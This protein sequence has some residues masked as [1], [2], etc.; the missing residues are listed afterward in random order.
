MRQWRTV[1]H[2]PEYL[3]DR[4]TFCR[5]PGSSPTADSHRSQEPSRRSLAALQGLSLSL[6]NVEAHA[7][8]QEQETRGLRELT[9]FLRELQTS[10]PIRSPAQQFEMLQ[11][12]R[13]WLLWLPVSL[14]DYGVKHAG[15]LIVLA[16]VYAAALIMERLFPDVGA[17]CFGNMSIGPMEEFTRTLNDMQATNIISPT[18][19]NPLALIEMPLE[20][21]AMTRPTIGL[22]QESDGLYS[23]IVIDHHHQHAP[24]P[25]MGR[26]TL[27]TEASD[28][29]ERTSARSVSYSS[30]G[31]RSAASPMVNDFTSP[32]AMAPAPHAYY[33]SPLGQVDH[34]HA[35]QQAH[36]NVHAAPPNHHA[37][38]SGM[39]WMGTPTS[40]VE[41]EADQ[42]Y[43]MA[44]MEF[45]HEELASPALWPVQ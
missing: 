27:E 18:F 36:A 11:P 4:S 28:M 21:M 24:A 16:H 1:S 43:K 30:D 13:S 35:H 25:A 12:L 9:S 10:L 41:A 32:H 33:G 20:V 7:A 29:S 26:L 19:P 17:V 6:Q 2:F 5:I 42:R 39:G 44:A 40:S 45:N 22:A 3:E 23:P 31:A 14:L 37:S 15:E 38:Y 8:C 34:Y